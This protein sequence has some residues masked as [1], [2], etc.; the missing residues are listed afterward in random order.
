M[1]DEH[2]ATRLC[3]GASDCA[4]DESQMRRDDFDCSSQVA[5]QNGLPK[6]YTATENEQCSFWRGCGMIWLVAWKYL[7]ATVCDGEMSIFNSQGTKQ[8]QVGEDA[9]NGLWLQTSIL[10][11]PAAQK[12]ELSAA[13][14]QQRTGQAPGVAQLTSLAAVV[15]SKWAVL[16]S[17]LWSPPSITI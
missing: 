4:L 7:D 10:S 5:E 2:G 13:S 14:I 11:T 1:A 12:R 3:C 17:I 15:L 16:A 8:P 9:P 6:R